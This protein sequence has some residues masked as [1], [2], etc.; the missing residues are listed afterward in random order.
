[1]LQ[2]ARV[3]DVM[4]EAVVYLSADT[5]ASEAADVLTRHRINGAPV[6]GKHGHV[7]GLVSKTDLLDRR[8]DPEHREMLVSDA[9]TRVV[10]AVRT[11]DPVMLAVRLMVEEEIHRAVVVN[12]DGTLAG[13]VAPMDILRGMVNGLNV[14]A[15]SHEPRFLDLR[16]LR[17]D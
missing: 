9:M 6:L 14:G 10:F 11:S 1:M 13:I 8:R 7:V 17:N 2:A 12:D 5:L 3:R 4:T 15:P 16:A